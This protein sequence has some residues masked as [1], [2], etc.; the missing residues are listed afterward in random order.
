MLTHIHT[1]IATMLRAYGGL[2]DDV[3]LVFRAPQRGW[4]QQDLSRTTLCCHLLDLRENT[5]L[6]RG[7]PQMQRA[8]NGGTQRMPPRMFDLRYVLSLYGVGES[9]AEQEFHLLWL[10]LVA[11]LKHSPLPLEWQ[12]DELRQL[13]RPLETRVVSEEAG[14]LLDLWNALGVTPR[15]ALLY[16]VT[17]PVDLSIV[18]G[19]F[20]PVRERVTQVGGRLIVRGMV[21]DHT[22]TPLEGVAVR[23]EDATDAPVVTKR[24]GAFVL[25]ATTARPLSLVLTPPAGEPQLFPVAVAPDQREVTLTFTL[26]D[27]SQTRKGT[28]RPK[29]EA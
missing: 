15:P 17:A 19:P 11:L 12:P 18:Q 16:S 4:P 2:P 24:N 14:R 13:G 29:K 6:R 21:R 5:E 9:A 22:A 1:T 23:Q 25:T 8:E 26:D 10:T 28:R 27:G 3:E 20:G 7:D